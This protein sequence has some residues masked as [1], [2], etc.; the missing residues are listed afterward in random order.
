SV[1]NTNVFREG[2]AKSS[3]V[4]SALADVYSPNQKYKITA[5]AAVSAEQEETLTTG[6]NL[7][8]NLGKVSGVWKYSFGYYET[9]NKYNPNDL[10]FL[11]ANNNRGITADLRRNTF[12][13]KGM[14]LRTWSGIYTYYE[15]LYSNDVFT[16]FALIANTNGT[17]KK[18]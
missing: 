15:Q 17:T 18:F 2:S 10:G 14:F 8:L 9:D 5:N 12:Q 6:H 7:N 1:V 16:D 4:T 13:P 11:R 3:N